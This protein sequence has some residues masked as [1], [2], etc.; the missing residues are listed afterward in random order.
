MAESSK[1]PVYEYLY[2]HAGTSTSFVDLQVIPPW[3][4]LL[5]VT[6]LNNTFFELVYHFNLRHVSHRLLEDTLA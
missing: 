6:K 5:K 1:A 4:H 3:K 2:T